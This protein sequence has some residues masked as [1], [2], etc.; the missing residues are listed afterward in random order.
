MVIEIIGNILK[1]LL[2]LGPISAKNHPAPGVALAVLLTTFPAFGF[3]RPE[4]K[5]WTGLEPEPPKPLSDPK[6]KKEEAS[7]F[8]VWSDRELAKTSWLAAPK[9]FSQRPFGR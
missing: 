7:R 3:R 6:Q 5:G 2:G 8:P 9:C 4:Q 1:G